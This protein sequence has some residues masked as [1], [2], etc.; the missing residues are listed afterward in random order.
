[1]QNTQPYCSCRAVYAPW[2]RS[3]ID[4]SA[5]TCPLPIVDSDFDSLSK[6]VL[7]VPLRPRSVRHPVFQPSGILGH[8]VLNLQL[9]THLILHQA[10][11]SLGTSYQIVNVHKF[12]SLL[13]LVFNINNF[14]PKE[15][16]GRLTSAQVFL[17]NQG[18][19]GSPSDAP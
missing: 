9:A 6:T 15:K 12:A 16:E 1:M 2:T 18:S 5:L 19:T 13:P 11:N 8:G 4:Q 17:S 3:L 10:G 14:K 7:F